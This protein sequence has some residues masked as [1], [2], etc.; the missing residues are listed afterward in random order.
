MHLTFFVRFIMRKKFIHLCEILFLLAVWQVL[1]RYYDVPI[2][3][4]PAPSDVFLSIIGNQHA[5]VYH[6]LST[7]LFTCA[8]FLCAFVLGVITAIIFDRFQKLLHITKTSLIALQ[9]LPLFVL[10]PI[11]SLWMGH[12]YAPKILII[13][14]SCFFP[15]C[16][17]LHEGLRNTPQEY[18]DIIRSCHA[19]Y[20]DALLHVRFKAA[21]P[22]L[23]Q[24]LK[25][26]AINAPVTVI[27]VD[28]IGS[29]EGLGYLILYTYGRLQTDL[30]FAAIIVTMIFSISFSKSIDFLQKK[31][32]FWRV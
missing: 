6:A 3:I 20:W 17:C 9:S 19:G 18:K 27:A 30:M 5:L 2:Y 21:L 29:S 8:A 25:L 11:L 26:A 28:W 14:L 4:L 10:L 13:A 24:G 32:I 16:L 31:I 23:F 12:G 1:V 15:I 7:F 22:Y